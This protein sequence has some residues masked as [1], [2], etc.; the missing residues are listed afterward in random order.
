M[1]MRR[2]IFL[3]TAV[4]AAFVLAGGVGAPSSN[5]GVG[6]PPV[7]EAQTKGVG[8]SRSE[9]ATGILNV[10]WGDPRP[11]SAA[12]AQT[13]YVLTDDEGQEK[14]LLLDKNDTGSVGGPLT[15]K[16]KRVKVKGKRA[17]NDSEQIDVQAIEFERPTDDAEA[18]SRVAAGDPAAAALTNTSKPWVTIGCRF[19]DSTGVTPKPMSYF[20]GPSAPGPVGSEGLMGASAPGMDN[21]WQELSFGQINLS[22]SRVERWYNLPGKRS[23]YVK[24]GS[25]NLTKITNDCT[26]AADKDVTFPNFFGINLVLNQ[27]IGSSSW[28]GSRTLTRDGKTQNYGVTWLPPFAYGHDWVTHEMGHG[29]GMPHSSGPYSATYDSEWDVMS[30]AGLCGADPN[31]PNPLDSGNWVKNDPY[32]C[33]ADHTI[34]YHKDLMGWIPLERKYKA[35]PGS[36]QTIAIERLGQGLSDP[37]TSGYLMAQIPI[38][39][40]TTRFYT[41][42]AR[43]NSGYDGHTNG[44]IPAEAIVIHKVDTALSSR[45]AQVVDVDPANATNTNANDAGAMWL[46]GETFT[47]AAN[48]I[49]VEVKG[50]T[51]TGETPSGYNV[52]ISVSQ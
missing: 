39:G 35:A 50:E 13:E 49:T 51:S 38:K 30:G 16:G 1:K 29:F 22:G 47:D 5:S 11:G 12:E 21:Y 34:S 31:G 46:P 9:T 52:N 25:P 27:D 7:A 14:K 26:A 17:S 45:N 37:S 36:N 41:V 15:F 43:R 6:K 20:G 18:R 19:A 8:N 33:I 42:E 44:R 32:G 48:G 40:S 28:G 4:G 23:A 2:A 24:G 3:L 10:Q